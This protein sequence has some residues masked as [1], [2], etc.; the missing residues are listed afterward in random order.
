MERRRRQ[1]PHGGCVAPPGWDAPFPQAPA[2]QQAC[3]KPS[4]RPA[5]PGAP[6]Q[7]WGPPPRAAAGGRGSAAAA[8]GA[9][10]GRGKG[11]LMVVESPAKASKIQKFLGSDYKARPGRGPPSRPR[12]E[13]RKSAAPRLPGAC[14]G[15]PSQAGAAQGACRFAAAATTPPPPPARPAPSPPP[16]C[17]RRPRGC[18]CPRQV[19]ASYGHV[20]DLPPK[21]GSVRPGENF[22]MDWE[23]LPRAAERVREIAAAAAGA[24]A[25][26]L[27]TDPDREGEAISW[28][29]LEELKVGSSRR[30]GRRPRARRALPQAASP[31]PRRGGPALPSSRACRRASPDRAAPGSLFPSRPPPA[32][33]RR[34]QGQARRQGH[35]Q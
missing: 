15:R 17:P 2:Q 26:L 25:V 8:A 23:M 4:P 7:V 30:A 1:R 21:P 33:A 13:P 6:R 28:H 11:T 22:A 35:V 16:A 29:V 24:R 3:P 27:A 19:L 9:G 12:G 34:G 18:P 5:S 32:A 10:A 14:S 20:R 31:Y